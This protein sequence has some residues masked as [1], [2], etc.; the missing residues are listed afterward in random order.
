MRH[1]GS[2]CRSIGR[3]GGAHRL[4]FRLTQR[5]LAAGLAEQSAPA[6]PHG[7]PPHG[8][9]H[10]PEGHPHHHHVHK[11]ETPW[12]TII[13]VITVLVVAGIIALAV[14]AQRRGAPTFAELKAK[15]GVP[16]DYAGGAIKMSQVD[17]MNRLGTPDHKVDDPGQNQKH[18][19]YSIRGGNAVI[20]VELGGW[21]VGEA[22]ILR[23]STR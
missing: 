17:F 5:H 12:G 1:A 15:L 16:A 14:V 4:A 11:P 18:L 9:E 22:R 13:G 21:E 6:Q 7:H 20:T 19:Y 3:V 10:P 8:H 2:F 23:I